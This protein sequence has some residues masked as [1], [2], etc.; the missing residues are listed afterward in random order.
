MLLNRIAAVLLLVAAAAARPSW[1]D[2]AV[3]AVAQ[4]RRQCAA[5]APAMHVQPQLQDAATRLMHGTPLEAALHASGY[6]AVRS[7]QWR[8]TGYQSPQAVTQMLVRNHCSTLRDPGLTELGVVRSGTTYSIIAA[9]PF[10][11]PPQGEA[12][13]V[14]A[15]VLA[16]VNRAR[17]QPH[18]CGSQT[19]PPA[20]PLTLN[21]ALAHA[22]TAHAE[23]MAAGNYL[24]HEGRD[25]SS[26]S[27]RASRAGYDWRSIGENIA[28]GQTTPEQVVQSWLRSPEH[29]ANIMEPAFVHM[30]VAFAVNQT[31]EGGIYWAQE[32]GRPR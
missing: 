1:A 21:A 8:L 19:F 16:L 26:P 9:A 27:Q 28:M 18:R 24:E 29:C 15:S 12:S 32:F 3:D 30:G 2:E 23:S 25:G 31:S 5:G 7:F 4:A 11:P 17:S 14:S 6:R 10:A 22:A 13:D 20:A